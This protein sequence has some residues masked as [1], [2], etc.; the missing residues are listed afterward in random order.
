MSSAFDTLCQDCG[1]YVCGACYGHEDDVSAVEH[2]KAVAKARAEAFEE[3]AKV[4]EEVEVLTSGE[5]MTARQ[6]AVAIRAK[7]KE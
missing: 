4:C 5:R 2:A 7:A 3:A 1:K 6:C